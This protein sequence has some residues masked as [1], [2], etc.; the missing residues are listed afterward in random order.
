VASDVGAL[1]EIIRP[2]VTGAL[3]SPQDPASFADSMEPLLYSSENRRK[4]GVN[5]REWVARD[6][7]WA[8]NAAIYRAAYERLG[9]V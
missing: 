1:R 2:E 3:A 6:R 5:A 7:T 9:A 8:R 4:L